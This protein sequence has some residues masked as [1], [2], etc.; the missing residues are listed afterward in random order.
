MELDR[1]SFKK[2]DVVKVVGRVDN[3][4]CHDLDKVLNQVLDDRRYN[5][6][7]DLEDVDF[8]SSGGLRALVAAY[9]ECKKH[10]GD[11][12]VSSP[13]ERVTYTLELAGH[14]IIYPIF[15]DQVSAVGSF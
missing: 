5:I 10:G 1:K 9:K 8:L 14:D 3:Y 7:I 6:V 2:V 4:N 15:E 11:I 12:R 13:S